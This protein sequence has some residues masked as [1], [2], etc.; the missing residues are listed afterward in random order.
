M[1]SYIEAE[2]KYIE[3]EFTKAL[4]FYILRICNIRLYFAIMY[5]IVI[6][7]TVLIILYYYAAISIV[8]LFIGAIFH[9][10]FYSGPMEQYKRVSK[11]RGMVIYR[12]SYENVLSSSVNAQSTI[13]WSA[14]KKSYESA[15]AFFLLD[16]NKFV[17][18]FPKICF[19]S[20]S[21]ID[22]LRDILNEKTDYA[23]KCR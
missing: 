12:F 2:I 18:I 17:Y 6:I 14:F 11:K 16:D 20:S 4:S 21:D 22:R 19:S 1:D 10:F 3:E 9:Y 7:A 15:S 23:K 13:M 5:F 8:F